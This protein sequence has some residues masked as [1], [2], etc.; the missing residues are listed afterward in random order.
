[1]T[2]NEPGYGVHAKLRSGYYAQRP[3]PRDDYTSLERAA[4]RKV[5]FETHDEVEVPDV[6][7][8]PSEPIHPFDMLYDTEAKHRARQAMMRDDGITLGMGIVS[9]SIKDAVT[10]GVEH[11][12]HD[13]DGW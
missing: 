7:E 6:V 3:K 9:E 5:A 2:M 13:I 8:E 1:M 11:P 4:R 10:S 12:T